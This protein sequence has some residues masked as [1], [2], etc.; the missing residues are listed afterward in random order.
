MT[1]RRLILCLTLMQFMAVVA[2]LSYLRAQSQETINA[3][4]TQR[5][6][7]QEARLERVEQEVRAVPGLVA[8]M[9]EVKWLGRSV[10]ALVTGQLVTMLMGLRDVRR[11]A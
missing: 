7:S 2:S 3:I 5:L 4:T 6:Q 10:A 8:D 11:R 1:I 9:A